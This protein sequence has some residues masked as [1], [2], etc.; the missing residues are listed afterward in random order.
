MGK[1][2]SLVADNWL[3]PAP[4]IIGGLLIAFGT[5]NRLLGFNNYGVSDVVAVPRM[6]SFSVL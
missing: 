1:V 3:A 4:I 6:P 2:R 5:P